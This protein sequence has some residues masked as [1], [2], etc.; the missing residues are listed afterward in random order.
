MKTLFA[1][2]GSIVPLLPMVGIAIP[3]SATP[4]TNVTGV[5]VDYERRDGVVILKDF[6]GWDRKQTEVAPWVMRT[7]TRKWIKTFDPSQAAIF[8]KKED[9]KR[10]RKGQRLTIDGYSY[11]YDERSMFPSYDKFTVAK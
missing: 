10:L 3:S 5:I 7:A 8:I 9:L 6:K 11:F 1:I 4:K 2:L